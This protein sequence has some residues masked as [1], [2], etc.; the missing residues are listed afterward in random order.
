MYEDLT[1]QELK[2]LLSY[3]EHLCDTEE[4]PDW[5]QVYEL[6]AWDLQDEIERRKT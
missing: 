5:K 6:E 1:F 4:D 2:D 3:T